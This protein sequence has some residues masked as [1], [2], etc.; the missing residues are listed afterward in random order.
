MS[1]IREEGVSIGSV[2]RDCRIEIAYG[3]RFACSLLLIH[4]TTQNTCTYT[5]GLLSVARDM[6]CMALG[7]GV[8]ELC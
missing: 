3:F 4:T 7:I 2:V 8:E 1:G 6:L 5:H